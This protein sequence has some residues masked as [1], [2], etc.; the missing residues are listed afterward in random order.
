M[1]SR[2]GTA[3]DVLSGTA[4]D[5]RNAESRFRGR[6][7]SRLLSQNPTR[8]IAESRFTSTRDRRR[9][10]MRWDVDGEMWRPHGERRADVPF[11][12]HALLV[13]Q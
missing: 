11:Q 8:V 13:Y 2:A 12:K 1:T 4:I 9:D 7:T 3:R 10:R 6:Q 5:M